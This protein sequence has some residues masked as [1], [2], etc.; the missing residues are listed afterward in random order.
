[1]QI[2]E[3]ACRHCTRSSSASVR[4]ARRELEFKHQQPLRLHLLFIFVILTPGF[5]ASRIPVVQGCGHQAS[6]CIKSRDTP[7]THPYP[8]RV[9]DQ[10]RTWRMGSD[11]H[12]PLRIILL[13]PV[14]SSV[15]ILL[16]FTMSS[17]MLQVRSHYA[18]YIHL[19]HLDLGLLTTR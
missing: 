14:T 12:D 8:Q 5:M 1:M 19:S 9:G 4:Q 7:H 18:T 17:G 2:Y 15:S 11:T 6:R 16:L 13:L 10:S 3:A